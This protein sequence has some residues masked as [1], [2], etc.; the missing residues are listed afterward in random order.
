MHLG[1]LLKLLCIDRIFVRLPVLEHIPVLYLSPANALHLSQ[2]Y[3]FMA[4]GIGKANWRNENPVE[5]KKLSKIGPTPKIDRVGKKDE[6]LKFERWTWALAFQ[7]LQNFKLLRIA[8][9]NVS[10]KLNRDVTVNISALQTRKWKIE[11]ASGS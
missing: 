6:F 1:G 10:E 3:S 7:I 2:V 9:I 4:E 8:Y 11:K 5:A